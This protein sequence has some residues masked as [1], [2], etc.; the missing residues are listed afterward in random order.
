[1]FLFRKCKH[2]M[3]RF[4]ESLNIFRTECLPLQQSMLQLPLVFFF[5]CL[6]YLSCSSSFHTFLCLVKLFVVDIAYRIFAV[7]Q[8]PVNI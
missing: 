6:V 2:F 1:M 5:L 7:F 8:K 3:H 4:F